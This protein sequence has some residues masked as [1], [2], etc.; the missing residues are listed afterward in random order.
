[1]IALVIIIVCVLSVSVVKRN[2][3]VYLRVID[4]ISVSK[5]S[6]NLRCTRST[7]SRDESKEDYF[8][9]SYSCATEAR[10]CMLVCLLCW[11]ATVTVW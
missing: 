7:V 6:A 2:D 3:T 11:Y 9:I 1:M 8:D 4:A 5:R 10:F